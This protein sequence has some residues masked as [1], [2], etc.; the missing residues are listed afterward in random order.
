[1]TELIFTQLHLQPPPIWRN[2]DGSSRTIWIRS[3]FKLKADSLDNDYSVPRISHIWDALMSFTIGCLWKRL[4]QINKANNEEQ[5]AMEHI[6][7]A[8]NVEKNQAEWS[9]QVVPVSYE[10][11]DYLRGWHQNR[12]TSW[13]PFG[14]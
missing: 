4:A 9:Q 3:Q 10:A 13:N 2:P 14:L 6:K 7:A 12:P 1:M 8:I 11:G 5:V